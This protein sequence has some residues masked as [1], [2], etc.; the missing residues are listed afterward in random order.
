MVQHAM[1]DSRLALYCAVYTMIAY[2]AISTYM[3]IVKRFG[4]VAAVLLATARKGMTLVLSF[5]LFP[6]AFSWFYVAGASLVL[7]GLL[8]ASLIKQKMRSIEKSGE[9]EPLKPGAQDVEND[10]EKGS[11]NLTGGEQGQG[12]VAIMQGSRTVEPAP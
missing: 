1:R 12:S 11:K 2:V 5:L 8:A 6:K 9:R 7:G 3:N 10:L 4:G